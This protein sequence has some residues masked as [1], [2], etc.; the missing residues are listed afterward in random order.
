MS[1]TDRMG[2]QM[3]VNS[4][5]HDVIAFLKVDWIVSTV[6]WNAFSSSLMMDGVKLI[7]VLFCFFKSA[8]ELLNWD[9]K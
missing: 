2:S 7:T 5:K 1:F 8:F 6:F 4:V 3:A 9:L